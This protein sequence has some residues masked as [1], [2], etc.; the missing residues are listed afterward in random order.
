MSTKKIRN[1]WGQICSFE[2]LHTA[3]LHARKNK[4]YRNDVLAFSA[5][6]EENLFDLQRQLLDHTYEVG[7]YREFYVYDPKKRLIMALPFTDRVVQ[8]A[9]YQVINPIY[10]SG[11]ISDSF[12]CIDGRGTQQ[13]IQRLHK[14]L[15]E[16]G[17]RP[18]KWYYLKL[19]VSKYFHRIDH[20]R[21]IEILRKKIKDND[22]MWLLES[23]IN[24]PDKAFG[25]PLNRSA[26]QI[27]PENRLPDKGM[28]IGNLTSQMFANI[29]L[30][31]LDQYC[32]RKLG[33]HY[34]IRYM[35]DVIILHDDKLQLGEYKRIIE[36]FLNEELL[37]DLNN[38]TALR[39]VTLGIEFV[40]YKLWNTHIKLKKASALKMKHRLR[41][42][43]KQ[44]YRWEVDLPK[45]R[46][47]LVSYNGVMKH[48]NCYNMRKKLYRG[49]VLKRGPKPTKE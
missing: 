4:R 3:Y 27:A 29:Y 48:C 26:D 34:Y 44:Y 45:I 25:L 20:A 28:P 15:K 38:K 18:E 47:T 14:W 13:A 2:N 31:R 36:K 43:K 39:P 41:H 11:Y 1:V 33:I 17:R 42:L 22:L 24:C 8:W 32:K 46:K 10:A 6:L 35:D 5:N 23:I 12:A 19:D 16:V 30:D 40:G 7:H 9:V 37:L 49:F 21:L